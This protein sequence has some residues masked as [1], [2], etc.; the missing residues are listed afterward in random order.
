[1]AKI[2]ATLTWAAVLV[3]AN[4]LL[5]GTDWAQYLVTFILGGAYVLL[6]NKMSSPSARGTD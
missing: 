2:I 6:M 1:M 4:K 5:S 3:G